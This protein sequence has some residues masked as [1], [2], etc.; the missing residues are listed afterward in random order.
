[1][2]NPDKYLDTFCGSPPY[3]SPELFRGESYLGPPV[4]IWALG[5][6]L[7]FM[8]TGNIPFRGDTVHDIKVKVLA[9]IYHIPASILGPCR[10]LMNGMLR[11]K[12]DERYNM[13]AIENCKWI[14]SSKCHNNIKLSESKLRHSVFQNGDSLDQSVLKVMNEFGVPLNDASLLLGEPR[15]PAAGIYRILL[16]QKI[17]RNNETKESTI[18]TTGRRRRRWAWPAGTC[19]CGGSTGRT[20]MCTI[21]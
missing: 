6:L 14:Q 11:F 15:T 19:T 13:E 20:K 17:N 10:S 4:D 7:Y 16:Q 1:M 9:G 8:S 2:A 21:L 12:A 18:A 3:S 5:V